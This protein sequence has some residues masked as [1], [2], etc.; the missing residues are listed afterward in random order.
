MGD[1]FK[2][3]QA[4]GFNCQSD[5]SHFPKLGCNNSDRSRYPQFAVISGKVILLSPTYP[6]KVHTRPFCILYW[7]WDFLSNSFIIDSKLECNKGK[8]IAK[9]SSMD[10]TISTSTYWKSFDYFGNIPSLDC[11]CT[12]NIRTFV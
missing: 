11:N 12:A 9:M 7:R 2:R 3:S 6:R 8:F 10:G 5:D 4:N 1:I